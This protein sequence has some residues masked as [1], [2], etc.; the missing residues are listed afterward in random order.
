MIMTVAG[1][2]GFAAKIPDLGNK[3]EAIPEKKA[4]L[5]REIENWH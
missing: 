4:A 2:I 1:R 5:L 3:P